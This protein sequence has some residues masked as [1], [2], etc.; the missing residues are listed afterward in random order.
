MLV[1]LLGSS[2][3]NDCCSPYTPTIALVLRHSVVGG[4]AH[5]IV[6]FVC[7]CAM[8]SSDRPIVKLLT[9]KVYDF[10][11]LHSK[12]FLGKSAGQ[13]FVL[14]EDI[15]G[16]AGCNEP[17]K[18]QFNEDV[19]LDQL[20]DFLV[21]DQDVLACLEEAKLREQRKANNNQKQK[22]KQKQKKKK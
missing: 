13:E 21:Q 6:F 7:L 1:A 18:L 15:V 9:E 8:S 2:S 19:T 11:V 20:V 14:Y 16:D 10:Q 3:G 4:G 22:Q 5:Y 17:F 12:A